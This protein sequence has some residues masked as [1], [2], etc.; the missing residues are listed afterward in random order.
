MYKILANL[1]FKSKLLHYLPSCHSTNE[2]AANLLAQNADEGAVVITDNQMAGKGQQSNLW[3]S[4]PYLNLTFSLILKPTF[5]QLQNQFQLTQAISISLASVVQD[6]VA[7]LVKIKWP[8]DIYVGNKK[9]AGILIQNNVKGKEMEQSIIGIGLNI[10]QVDFLTPNAVSLKG[11]VQSNFDLNLILNEV[12]IAIS[13][14]YDRLKRGQ[15][16]LLNTE[17][18]KLLYGLNEIRN[19]KDENQFAG[20]IIGTDPLGRLLVETSK[21]VK[22][23]QNQEVKFLFN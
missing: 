7:N 12:L 3:E 17:Y 8:N 21:G 6:R 10:N 19:F 16:K 1:G 22:C 18:H 23:Y 2:I 4:D 11:L 5:L 14:N 13:E 9:I 15:S 20:K